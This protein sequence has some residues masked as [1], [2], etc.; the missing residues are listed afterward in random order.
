M[1]QPEGRCLDALTLP[2]GLG[3]PYDG[4]GGGTGPERRPAG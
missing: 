3:E 1:V 2:I 4:G